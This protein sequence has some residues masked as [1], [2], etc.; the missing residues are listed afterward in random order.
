M[1]IRH[2]VG[3]KSHCSR[4][5][6]QPAATVVVAAA[7]IHDG[8]S[9]A[10][11]NLACSFFNPCLLTNQGS[12]SS[13]LSV[14]ALS[15]SLSLLPDKHRRHSSRWVS[16]ALF[17]H[18]SLPHPPP[19]ISQYLCGRGCVGADVDFNGGAGGCGRAA[20]VSRHNKQ[21]KG[22]A[23]SR[24]AVVSHS[25][26][27][28]RPAQGSL[29]LP[30]SRSHVTLAATCCDRGKG[31]RKGPLRAVLDCT[32][33]R[34][35]GKWSSSKTAQQQQRERGTCPTQQL[36]LYNE[37]TRHRRVC[38]LFFFCCWVGWCGAFENQGVWRQR[39]PRLR[40]YSLASASPALA[41]LRKR[42]S[43]FP[44]LCFFI[45]CVG[46]VGLDQQQQQ[47]CCTDLTSHPATRQLV[48]QHP[49]I[50]AERSGLAQREAE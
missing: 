34:I 6:H 31:D 49:Q 16:A 42:L 18:S 2:V 41:S 4:G 35:C 47:Y 12:Q 48:W 3:E 30:R 37:H 44:L 21:T 22:R 14:S 27:G 50:N 33:R 26:N 46:A 23:P 7:A 45:T 29:T 39:D 28:T 5:R 15:L 24:S 17:W 25:S 9:C 38:C 8:V 36:L 43:S 19:S 40:Y 10:L 11:G 1:H 13:G 20:S 32:Y